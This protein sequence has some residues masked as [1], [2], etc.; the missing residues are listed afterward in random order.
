M[1][2]SLLRGDRD[3]PHASHGPAE[4][5]CAVE[6]GRACFDPQRPLSCLPSYPDGVGPAT[7]FL[8]RARRAVKLSADVVQNQN[9]GPMLKYHL[10]LAT[11]CMF[12]AQA[13]SSFIGMPS[14]QVRMPV[15][16]DQNGSRRCQTPFSVIPSRGLVSPYQT[17]PKSVNMRSE[18]HT[19]E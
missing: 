3:E 4:I 16:N 12:V 7:R 1:R 5:V 2:D 13:T 15:P 11:Y 6:P 19:S 14:S 18:E 9:S 10:G 8:E 17:E